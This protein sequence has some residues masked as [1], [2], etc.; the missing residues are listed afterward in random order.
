MAF[1]PIN[2]FSCRIDPRGVSELLRRLG[3]AKVKGDDDDW[4]EIQLTLKKNGFLSKAPVITFGHHAEYYDGEDW[5]R[6]VMGMQ[7]YFSRFP[8]TPT[9]RQVLRTIGSFRFAL[10]VPQHDL[11]IESQDERLKVLY[12]VCQHLDGVIFTPSALRDAQGRVLL[13][14]DGEFDPAAI[15]PKLPPQD[16]LTDDEEFEVEDGDELEVDE[17]M[18]E[19]DPPTP[20]RVARRAIALTAVA[21]RATLELD[22]ENV[23]KPDNH[24]RRI[25]NWIE[26]LGIG[27]ELE[28]DEWKVLQ[29]PVGTLD[30][31]SFLDSMWRIEGLAVL[32]WSLQRLPLPADDVLID[33]NE[34]YEAMGLFDADVGAS[35]LANPELRSLDELQAKLTHLLMLHWRIRDFSIRPVAMDFVEFS[36]D[37]W[38]GSFDISE[39]R[40]LQ[41]DL[42][43]GDSPIAEAE[44]DAVSTVQ[45]IAMERH[46]AINWLNG[47]SAIYS[48]TDTST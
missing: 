12:A 1:E 32:A 29:R 44:E 39:F 31:R 17:E 26:E 41:N 20:E 6:Q 35:I 7:G 25:L 38:I 4:E 8:E 15:L 42:A 10:T 30:E 11:D 40:I 24:R 13:G 46:L 2:I 5:P 36:K 22:R 34:I 47:Y 23:D 48:E 45:S 3:T 43:I 28:P 19:P 21:A 9:K 18:A 27:D 16:D 14:G 37:C 33:P